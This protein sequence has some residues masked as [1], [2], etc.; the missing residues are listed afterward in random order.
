VLK[1]ESSKPPA[2]P[3]SNVFMNMLQ[4]TMP[5]IEESFLKLLAMDT[6]RKTVN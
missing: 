6:N 4:L 2:L 3:L 1:E 5:N